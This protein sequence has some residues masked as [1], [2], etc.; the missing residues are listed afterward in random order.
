M[1][2]GD[3]A[4]RASFAGGILCYDRQKE[5]KNDRKMTLVI[6]EWEG[7]SIIEGIQIGWNVIFVK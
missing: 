7:H 3:R 5:I 1:P 2:Q 4:R 6:A